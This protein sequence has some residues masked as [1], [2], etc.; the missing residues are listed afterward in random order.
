MASALS[1]ATPAAAYHV[2]HGSCGP[3]SRAGAMRFRWRSGNTAA[4][5]AQVRR[6]IRTAKRKYPQLAEH[7]IQL[8]TGKLG[9]AAELE[10]QVEELME[11]TSSRLPAWLQARLPPPPPPPPPPLR[12]GTVLRPPG[13]RRSGSS[14]QICSP[15][16]GLASPQRSPRLS[17]L[18]GWWAGRP[19]PPCAVVPGC[20]E[21]ERRVRVHG[22][23]TR[24]QHTIPAPSRSH[25]VWWRKVH[26]ADVG[27]GLQWGKQTDQQA[28]EVA[29]TAANGTPGGT[30]GGGGSPAGSPEGITQDQFR[31]MLEGV[32]RK[33]RALPA[34]AQVPP[35]PSP[36]MHLPRCMWVHPVL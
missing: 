12:C 17:L 24:R 27:C 21:Q 23:G 7:A 8:D 33:L 9:F 1:P 29:V 32:D 30:A 4:A 36:P 5:V 3:A 2:P 26:H 18:R 16:S 10:E 35:H 15:A 28:T 22:E 11:D 14:P 19:T 31:S 25:D 20:C 13:V 6:L 34:T